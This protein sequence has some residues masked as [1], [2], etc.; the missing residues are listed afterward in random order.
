MSKLCRAIHALSLADAGG[1]PI[2]LSATDAY[3]QSRAGDAKIIA[4]GE[5]PFQPDRRRG[6]LYAFRGWDEGISYA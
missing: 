3:G 6:D 1:S 2:G 4:L 5:K